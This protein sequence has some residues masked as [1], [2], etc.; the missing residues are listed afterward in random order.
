[1]QS[2]QTYDNGA[3][4]VGHPVSVHA[5]KWMPNNYYA[6]LTL[7]ATTAAENTQFTA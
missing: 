3:S 1:M 6:E 7:T 4:N 2:A 5:Q